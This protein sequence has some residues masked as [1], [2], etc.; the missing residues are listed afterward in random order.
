MNE[1]MAYIMGGAQ[2]VLEFR[3]WEVGAGCRSNGLLPMPEPL[4]GAQIPRCAEAT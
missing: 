4:S 1:S 3:L 2:R